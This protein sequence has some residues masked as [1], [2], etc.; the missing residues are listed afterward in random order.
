MQE[1]DQLPHDTFLFPF[2]LSAQVFDFLAPIFF[3]ISSYV[4]TFGSPSTDPV[5]GTWLYIFG[6]YFLQTG[7]YLPLDIAELELTMQSLSVFLLYV[8]SMYVL[9]LSVLGK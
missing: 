3:S 7:T 4:V 9:S 5:T 6:L 8:V 2:A 1:H